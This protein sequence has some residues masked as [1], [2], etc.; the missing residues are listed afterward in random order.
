MQV[1]GSS[2]LN[3]SILAAQ[4]KFCVKKTKEK[5]IKFCFIKLNANVSPKSLAEG[6]LL[7]GKFRSFLS[8][9]IFTHFI[10]C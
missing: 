10:S 4:Q 7:C 8:K 6:G 5:Y 1:P 3:L 9:L 2:N